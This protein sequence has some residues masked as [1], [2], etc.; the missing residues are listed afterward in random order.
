MFQTKKYVFVL[1]SI[2]VIT[3]INWLYHYNDHSQ[4]KQ[5]SIMNIINTKIND[6]YF[7]NSNLPSCD[8]SS[9]IKIKLNTE[10]MNCF[11]LSNIHNIFDLLINNTN[12]TLS[13]NWNNN[14]TNLSKIETIINNNLKINK[15]ITISQ[16]SNIKYP[17][18]FYKY[19]NNTQKF[20]K[21][22]KIK[23]SNELLDYIYT[24]NNYIISLNSNDKCCLTKTN[25][26]LYT[27]S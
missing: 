3:T 19:D 2:I 26:Y 11:P 20:I 18:Q 24:F 14:N 6:Y 17:Q 7:N 5:F 23:K 4:I 8:N 13:F 12:N 22:I 9:D 15:Y 27:L 25:N 16:K 10:F 1:F 21:T